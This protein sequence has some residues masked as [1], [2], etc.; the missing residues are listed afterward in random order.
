M[1]TTSENM[2]ER[3][4]LEEL[5]AEWENRSQMEEGEYKLWLPNFHEQVAQERGGFFALLFAYCDLDEDNDPANG[6]YRCLY[7]L[8][9]IPHGGVALVTRDVYTLE[10][11]VKKF[12]RQMRY[13]RFD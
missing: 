6:K 13:Q 3:Q 5:E 8:V 12:L 2:K 10:H 9:P 1:D 4:R 7:P 11:E